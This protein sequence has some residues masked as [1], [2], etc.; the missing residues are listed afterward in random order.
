[1]FPENEVIMFYVMANKK[2]EYYTLKEQVVLLN[3]LL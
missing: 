3:A 2:F 1:M